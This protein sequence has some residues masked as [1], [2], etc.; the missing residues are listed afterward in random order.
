M[1]AQ[2]AR[3]SFSKAS[4]DAVDKGITLVAITDRR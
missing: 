4:D 2:L 3:T 1:D